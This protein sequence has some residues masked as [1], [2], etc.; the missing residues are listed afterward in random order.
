MKH[1]L[2]V[3]MLGAIVLFSSPVKAETLDITPVGGSWIDCDACSTRDGRSIYFLANETFSTEGVSWYG[4]ISSGSYDVV[5]YEG[6]GETQPVGSQL[7]IET[8]V[9]PGGVLGFN[10]IDIDFTFTGGSEYVVNFRR[11]DGGSSFSSDFQ[12]MLWGNGSESSNLGLLT[13][14]DGRSD[15][16]AEQHDNVWLTHFQ[17]GAGAPTPTFTVGGTVSGLT[18][19]GLELENMGADTLPVAADGPFTFA[20][21]LGV[22]VSYVVTVSTEPTGQTC[23]VSNGSGTISDA[24]VTDVAVTCTDNPEPLYTINGS[25]SGLGPNSVTLQNNLTD[26]LVVD[27]NGAFVFATALADGS[28]Y[29]VTVLTQPTGQ[30]CD[31]TNGNGT[32]SSSDVLGV[33]VDCVDDVVAPPTPSVPIPTLS[34]WALILLTMFIGLMVFANRRRLF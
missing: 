16:S 5:I 4:N 19:T 1:Y 15:F 11:T 28:T 34:E 32:I 29:D 21:A 14:L 20:T 31:V 25:A 7:A 17:F 10:H 18:G 9:F 33:D 27:A 24:N 6:V 2:V 8:A 13:L 30:T 23:V 12:Y 22:G 26:D 3:I